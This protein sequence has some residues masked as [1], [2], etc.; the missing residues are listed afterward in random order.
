MNESR[1]LAQVPTGARKPLR[2]RALRAFQRALYW[3]GASAAF[4]RATPVAGATI[5]MYHSV[6]APETAPWIDPRNALRP[7]VFRDQM[8]FLAEHRNV[9][10]MTNLAK[11]LA[12]GDT[13]SAGSVVI[14]FDDGYLDNL[15][16]AA[17]ILE[18]LGLPALLYLPTG[19]ISRAENQ[20]VDR[21]YGALRARTVDRLTLPGPRVSHDWDL[22]DRGVLRAAYARLC[23][24]LI[25][26]DWKTREQLLIEIS[27]QLSPI[28]SP[29]RLTMDW[30]DVRTLVRTHSSFEMGLHT[31]D[32]TDLSAVT[33][34]QCRSE[35][36]GCMAELE[37][38]TCTA[39]SHFSYP[40]GRSSDAARRAVF[41]SGIC[42][43]VVTESTT[44]VRPGVDCLALPRVES[45][46]SNTLFRYQTSGAHPE[47]SMRLVQRS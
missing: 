45:P 4:V 11:T 28:A 24:V 7:D 13:P 3:S 32:H 38:E 26:A 20:W 36:R 15:T 41:E 9:I 1:T 25:V 46:A 37:R 22:S 2:R 47:L 8:E 18:R 16:V 27:G 19:Y 35:I 31:V 42:T 5:L 29:P 21:L 6:P 34:A 39:A 14:T 33:D 12:R 43:A 44:L 17:P 40:Y 30:D 10:S 23:G